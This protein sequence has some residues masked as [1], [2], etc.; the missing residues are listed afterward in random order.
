MNWLDDEIEDTG[1]LAI[2]FINEFA[3][4]LQNKFIPLYEDG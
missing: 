4:L 1:D 3:N 2:D